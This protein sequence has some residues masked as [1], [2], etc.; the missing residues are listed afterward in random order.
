MKL[1]WEFLN[2]RK[3]IVA[4][5]TGFIGK[6][7]VSQLTAHGALCTVITRQNLQDKGSIRYINCDLNDL[8][9][10]TYCRKFGSEEYDLAIYMAANIPARDMKKESYLDAKKSTLD[11]FLHFC[12]MFLPMVKRLIYI[13]SVDAL[14]NINKKNYDEN[15]QPDMPTPYGLAKFCG[16]LYAEQMCRMNHIN[17]IIL[18][19]AQVYGGNEP[20]VRIIPILID[21]AKNNKVFTL[22]TTG[23]EKR[24]FLYIKDAVLSVIC[25]CINDK[26]TGTFNIA[27]DGENSINELIDIVNR[28]YNRP[29]NLIRL[30]TAI[31]LDNIPDITKAKTILGYQP[32]YYLENGIKEIFEG[33]LS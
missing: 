5:G 11:P 12:N 2:G 4:G 24:K 28:I 26:A 1:N 14:G 3:I 10:E 18:R 17:C 27:G 23:E 32:H 6:N 29:I 19:F 33:E 21:A 9:Q 8:E 7:V 30:N 25:A 16:E 20:F 15:Q 13:S 31:G 22:Y